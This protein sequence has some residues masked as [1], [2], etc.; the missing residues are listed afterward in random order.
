M[1]YP[2]I[3]VLLGVAA[4][5]WAYVQQR[6][7]DA[8]LATP[9]RTCAEIAEYA[10]PVTCEVKGTA[11][12]G[13]QGP[14]Q[15][16]FSGQPCV[17]HRTKVTVR[18]EHHEQRDGRTVTTTRERTVHDKTYGAPFSVRDATGEIVVIH[19]GRSIDNVTKSLSHF[20]RAGTDVDLFGLRL[21][22]NLSNVK[23]HQYEEWLIPAGQPMYVLGGAAAENGRLVMRD[24]AE[25][26]FLISTRSEEALSSA[27]RIRF[28]TGYILGGAV[29]VGGLIW[30]VVNLING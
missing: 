1:L 27:L 19:G 20:E 17:W 2:S 28:L 24:P 9:T 4:L 22:V 23:G 29:I 10:Q 5:I 12:P 7:R 18:Y 13:P 14:V 3:L 30:L 16:P 15:A 11:G 8:M 21:R 6:K 26:P 25:G